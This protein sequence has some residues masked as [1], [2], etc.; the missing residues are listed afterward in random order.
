MTEKHIKKFCKLDSKCMKILENA[1]KNF[2]FSARAYS[3]IIKLSRT[4]ADIEGSEEI[5]ENHIFE[6]LQYRTLDKE[7]YF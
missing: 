4:I 6:A 3:R 2:G 7:K 1:I 5:R